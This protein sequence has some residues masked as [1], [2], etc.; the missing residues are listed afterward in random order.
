[1]DQVHKWCDHDVRLHALSIWTEII[2]TGAESSNFPEILEE[3]DF[4]SKQML[5]DFSFYCHCATC[6]RLQC[7]PSLIF[8]TSSES[9][10]WIQTSFVS[11]LPHLHLTAV[12]GDDGSFHPEHQQ[13]CLHAHSVW[14][15]CKQ[16]LESF[17][18]RVCS[19]IFY[20]N[21]LLI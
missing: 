15:D 10:C 13:K 20:S 9:L 12:K 19:T 5:L 7:L 11:L 4:R 21:R 17:D 6:H 8:V 2:L 1:M 16:N 14:S 3:V 18:W